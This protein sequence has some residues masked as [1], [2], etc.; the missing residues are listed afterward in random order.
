DSLI[1]DPGRLRQII[2]NLVGNAIKFTEHGE[3]VT[4]IDTEFQDNDEV[5]LHFAITDTGIGIPSEK[6]KIIFDP[7][8]QADGS[9]TRKYGGSG[10][11][12]AITSLLV[13]ALGGR[14]WVESEAGNGSAFHFTVRLS[15]QQ[16]PAKPAAV[17]PVELQG[18]RVLI[19]DD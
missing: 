8:A 12:L 11:G 10:L 1:G 13:E 2:V 6:Q 5:F 7:F 17:A 15:L 14:I 18:L 3:V 9:T 4:S 16:N 19:V